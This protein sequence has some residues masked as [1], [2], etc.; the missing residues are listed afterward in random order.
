VFNK[1]KLR[2][3][4]T[5][6][7]VLALNS[8]MTFFVVT[9]FFKRDVLR[10]NEASVE[11]RLASL[12]KS[13]LFSECLHTYPADKNPCHIIL[14]EVT[15]AT[16]YIIYRK[17]NNQ[18]AY[19]GSLSRFLFGKLEEVVR[20]AAQ[21]GQ[22]RK[23]VISHSWVRFFSPRNVLAVAVPIRQNESFVD[24]AVGIVIPFTSVYGIF[25]ESYAIISAY[26][27]VNILVFIV[28]G[29]F[30][31]SRIITSPV[32]K[33]VD[34]TDSYEDEEGLPFFSYQD[35]DEFGQ[36]SRSLN[37]MLERI[38]TDRHKLQQHVAS[39]E[40]ANAEIISTRNEMVRAE[41]LASVGRLAAGLAH[42]IGNPIGI[43]QGFLGLLRQ[44]DLSDA[45]RK[46]FVERS[47]KELE[48]INRLVRGLLDFSRVR[49]GGEKEVSIHEI[50][51][52]VI[53]MME[54]QPAMRD[55]ALQ[56]DFKDGFDKVVA[57]PDQVQQVFLNC[58]FN[59]VDALRD[60]KTSKKIITIETENVTDES[61]QKFIKICLRD[62]GIGMDEEV[63]SKVFDPFFT[64]K[65]PGRGTG[66]GLS[67]VHSLIQGMK[68]NV[69]LES[70][71]G[72]GT[73]VIIL[74][75]LAEDVQKPDEE[76]KNNG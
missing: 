18:E 45:E 5:L 17:N 12:V 13:S 22:D 41:K 63:L 35:G 28:I 36:L 10:Q 75:P 56:V 1:L 76:H 74:L 42:E 66:L 65:E 54:A 59:G 23:K 15:G 46:E 31:F 8:V 26:L 70:T 47:E 69:T 32:Q 55:V 68:G 61:G 60:I 4:S 3:I 37:R 44:D 27:L 73:N 29:F 62:N 67:V 14:S 48:R 33:L 53:S 24:G 72:S 50:V 52:N 49:P 30:R 71:P 11:R 21:S 43:V 51:K 6:F 25:T 2:I 7:V 34:L 19:K 57:N 9:V 16:A 38:K 64:T 58:L 40:A 39:L 20:E